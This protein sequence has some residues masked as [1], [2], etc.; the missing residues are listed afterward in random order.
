MSYLFYSYHGAY[1]YDICSL[2][3]IQQI[4]VEWVNIAENSLFIFMIA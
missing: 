2:V 4:F 3:Y 1:M